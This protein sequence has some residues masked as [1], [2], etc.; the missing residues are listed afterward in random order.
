MIRKFLIVGLGNPGKK[1]EKTRHNAGRWAIE[2]LEKENLG[3]NILYFTPAPFMNN[4]GQAVANMVKKN[5]IATDRILI[6]HDDV[7]IPIGEYKIQKGVSSAGHNGVKSVIDAF[8]T[9][10][11]YRLRIGIG[12]PPLGKTT[13]DFVLEWTN[14]VDYDKII[15]VLKSNEVAEKLIELINDANY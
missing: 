9:N 1:Y 7:D 14:K 12:R 13:E 10:N 2:I 11:F 6:I 15:S 5:G 4:S 3:D 8:T